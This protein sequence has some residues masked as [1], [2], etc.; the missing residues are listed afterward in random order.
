MQ[1]LQEEELETVIMERE[2]PL[3]IAA[4]TVVQYQ[5]ELE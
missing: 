5:S 3:P 4:T 2:F 1:Q